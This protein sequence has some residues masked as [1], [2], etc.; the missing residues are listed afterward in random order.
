MKKLLLFTALSAALVLGVAAPATADVE[1]FEFASFDGVYELNL[2]ADGRSVLTTTETIVANFPEFDQNEGIVRALVDNFDGHPVDIDVTS[3]TD[4]NGNP[5]TFELDND[6]EFLLVTVRD[7]GTYVR[8]AQTYVI[9]Y[10]QHN[11]TRYFDNTKADEFYW[12]TNGTGSA[13]PYGRVSATVLLGDGLADAVTA[14]A[15]YVGPEDSR[16]TTNISAVEG[17]YY[18][19]FSN[20]A[21]GENLTVS[22]GF[23]PGTF[24]E[25]DGSFFAAPWPLLSLIGAVGAIAA[26]AIAGVLRTTRLRDAPGRPTI[27]AEYLPP[28]GESLPRAALISATVAK[29]TPAHIV[30][31]AVSGNIRIVEL[32]G[33]KASYRLEF[34]TDQGAAADDLEFLHALFGAQLTV[35]EDRSLDTVDDKAAKKITALKSRVS[36]DAVADGYR[37]PAQFGAV[38]GVVALGILTSIVGVI[39]GIGSLAGAYGGAIPAMVIA[40]SIVA[41][42]TCVVLVSKS[43][44]DAKGSELRDYLA[45]LK[46]YISLAEADRLRYLQSPQGAQTTPIAADDTAQLVKLNERLLPYAILFG[47]EKDWSKQLGRYYEDLGEQPQ[48]YTGSHAFSAAVF[49]SSMSTLSTSAASAYTGSSSSGGSGGGGFSGGGGGGGGTGGV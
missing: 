21:P 49:M 17:G 37:R 1:N 5:R 41:F 35:G 14:T 11:V 18:A 4:E 38:A 33:K 9:T 23:D 19:E 22:I 45:G 20:V 47:E 3:V 29:S 46:L 13:Q 36:K 44:L 16:D 48:W 10:T 8:G 28:Q 40:V 6:D 26:A 43:P 7:E 31:L 34:V 25:R 24:V 15:A 32:A 12:D 30:K 2:D 39:F 27:I 42:L